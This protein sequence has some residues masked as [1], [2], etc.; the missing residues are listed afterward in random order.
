MENNMTSMTIPGPGSYT[1]SAVKPEELGA[2]EYTLAHIV[3]DISSSVRP[4]AGPLMDTIKSIVEACQKSDRSENLMLRITLFNST[5]EELHG[6]K[7][8]FSIVLDDYEEL[9]PDGM[10]AL[11]DATYDA[12]GSVLTYAEE[13]ISNDYSA[14]GTIFI[15]SDGDDNMSTRGPADIKKLI[16]QATQGEKIESLTTILIGLKDPSLTNDDWANTVAKYL[17]D[18]KDQAG[19]TDFLN[20]G[21][22]SPRKLAKVATFVSQSISSTSKALGSGVPSQPLSVTF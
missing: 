1:F 2:T 22:A 14:N 3:C 9:N 17:A 19:L 4:F 20:V 16:A 7:E 8:L 18:F 21:D 10:T 5:I 13:L 11:F 15:I 6:F 12:V